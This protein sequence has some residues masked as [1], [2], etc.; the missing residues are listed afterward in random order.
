MNVSQLKKPDASRC[1]FNDFIC[2]LT[3]DVNLLDEEKNKP[4]GPSSLKR[5]NQSL[6]VNVSKPS[7]EKRELSLHQVSWKVNLFSLHFCGRM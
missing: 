5:K 2:Y 3:M 1:W 7:E 4:S 6:R